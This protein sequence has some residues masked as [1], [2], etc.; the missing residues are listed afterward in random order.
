MSSTAQSIS[1]AQPATESAD[2]LVKVISESL[3]DQMVERLSVTV[4]NALDVL[5]RLNDDHT[6]DAL[7]SLLDELTKLHRAGGLVSL[8]ELINMLN[9]IRNAMTDSMVERLA[10]FAESMVTNMANEDMAD[11]VGRTHTALM[12]AQDEMASTKSPGGLMASLRLLSAPE[13]QSAL[14][15]LVSVSKHL[16]TDEV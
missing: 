14:R 9:A 7:H 8:F 2:A 10:I 4:G 3:T 1:P 15:F 6:R 5:D 16:Q 13:T 11:L 12:E